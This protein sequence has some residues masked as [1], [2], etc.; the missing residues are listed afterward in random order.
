MYLVVDAALNYYF[1]R[2]VKVRLVS[3]GGVRLSFPF[4]LFLGL[5]KLIRCTQLKKYQKLVRFNTQIVFVSLSMDVLII[6]MMWLRND[7]V[8]MQFVSL[9]S[10]LTKGEGED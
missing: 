7:F 3:H 5:A 8:Y 4:L 9:F 10:S 1:I 6:A 2:T